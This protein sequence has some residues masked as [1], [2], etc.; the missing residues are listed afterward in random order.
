MSNTQNLLSIKEAI[1]TKR[2][3]L[4]HSIIKW[5]WRFIYWGVTGVIAIF[6]FINFTGIPSFRELEDPH[7][8][9]ASEIYTANRELLGRYYIENRVPVSYEE[10]SPHLVNALLSIED[11]RFREHCGID[12]QAVGRV[13]VRTIVLGDRSGG[14]GS[15]ITQQLAKMLYSDRNIQSSNKIK[16]FLTL[17]HIKLREW[18]TA[19][20]LEKSYTK[21]EI[22]AMYLNQFNFVNNA[23]GIRA[24]SEIYFGVRQ[25]SLKVEEAAML[26]GM[27][28]NPSRFNPLRFPEAC[29]KKRM[30]V[31]HQMY[32]HGHLTEDEYD[33][34]KVRPLDM[35]RFKK[36][37]ASENKAPYLCAELK[38]DL[39]TIL[40]QPECRK[41][42]GSKYNIYKD[43]LRITTT[44]DG[45]YQRQAEAAVLE[46]MKKL[47]KRFFDVWKGRD[48]WTYKIYEANGEGTTDEEIDR[49]KESLWDIVRNSDRYQSLRPQFLGE[50]SEKLAGLYNDFELRDV[51]IQRMMAEERKAGAISKMVGKKLVPAEMAAVY[52][53]ILANT[54]DWTEVKKQYRNLQAAVKKQ[55]ETKKPMKVFA[56]NSKFEK[57][58]LLSPLDSIKYH[59][60]FLQAGVLAVDPTSNQVKAWVGGV[61]FKYFQYDI[62]APCGKWALHSNPL[63]TPPPFPNKA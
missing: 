58:T 6:I 39:S 45:E 44:I 47:Q 1:Q 12:A 17:V 57:D 30:L 38:E 48:P 36:E 2:Q 29:I 33:S 49:R 54:A 35:S 40:N 62:S 28:Q 3:P 15:T 42:D 56:Y 21:E 63:C 50:I 41:S 60:M 32:K 31:L 16:K 37:N 7:S 53:K 59:R 46:N 34:L 22:I 14:G 19:V 4:Y 9:V 61:N 43:G 18:I 10:L 5:M 52:R 25:D 55:Y 26:I 8:A 51:D 23:Y 13:L 27:L 24:A 20:K 11:E